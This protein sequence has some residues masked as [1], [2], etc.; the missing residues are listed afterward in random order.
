M[1]VYLIMEIKNF[2]DTTISLNFCCYFPIY[3]IFLYTLLVTY[4]NKFKQM[5]IDYILYTLR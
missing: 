5:P 1:L 3:I 2:V 4:N